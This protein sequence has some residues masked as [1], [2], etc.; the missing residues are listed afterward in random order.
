MNLSPLSPLTKLYVLKDIPLDNS[1]TDTL[2]F[3]SLSEQVGWFQSKTKYHWENMTTIRLNN[4]IRI[5]VVADNVY[6]CNYV[7]WQNANFG[8][9]WFFGFITNIEWININSCHITVELDV[10]Q[11]WYFDYKLNPCWIERQHVNDDT[12]GSNLIDDNLE[13]GEYVVKDVIK[14]TMWEPAEID[15]EG[16]ITNWYIVLALASNEEGGYFPGGIMNGTYSGLHLYPQIS[17]SQTNEVLNNLN[18]LGKIDS[19]V[20]IYMCPTIFFTS[21]GNPIKNPIGVEVHVSRETSNIDGYI[22][23][24]KKLFT[25][26]YCFVNVSNLQGNMAQYRY[27]YFRNGTISFQLWGTGLPDSEIVCAPRLYKGQ[28]VNY[29]EMITLNNFPTC[30]FVT[31]YYK[32]WL[33]QN[34]SSQS[35]QLLG[36]ALSSSMG[37]VSGVVNAGKKFIPQLAVADFALQGIGAVTNIMSQKKTAQVHAP[38]IH[39]NQTGSTMFA[40]GNFDFLFERTNITY[41][42]AKRIDDYWS[43]YGYPIHDVTTPNRTGRQNWNYVKTIGCDATGSIPFNDIDKIK[44]IFDNGVTFWHSKDVGNYNLP[45]GIV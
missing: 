1:Y 38:Q 6:D 33:A 24:N 22:P 41:N 11:T 26:P 8:N 43:M 5:P 35:T 15:S 31:D 23:K 42:F 34:K 7:L 36:T 19:V 27:E 39:G 29:D 28:T 10:M 16:N 45:N 9:K 18:T 20:T 44:S 4:V 30:S 40:T 37:L 17:E 32:A 14:N 21:G 13:L 2:T 25:Y 12:I 3:G